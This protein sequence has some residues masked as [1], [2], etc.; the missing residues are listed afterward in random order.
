MAVDWPNEP[1]EG[2]VIT[3]P[4]HLLAARKSGR[5]SR[6]RGS[7]ETSAIVLKDRTSTYR[8]GSRRGWSNVTDPSWIE[9]EAWRFDRR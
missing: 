2:N 8:D 5:R 4:R 3:L 9:R 1:S 6:E 7:E